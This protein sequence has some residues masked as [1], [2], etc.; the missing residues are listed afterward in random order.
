MWIWT[1][2]SARK[3]ATIRAT[4]HFTQPE[5]PES[6]RPMRIKIEDETASVTGPF[7]PNFISV[8][9]KLTGKKKWLGPG[10][11]QFIPNAANIRI[12]KE[13]YPQT[14]WD[15]KV[16]TVADVER[17]EALARKHAER[18]IYQHPGARIDD[19]LPARVMKRGV[20]KALPKIVTDYHPKIKPWE[21]QEEGFR[22][23]AE[24]PE[25][26]LLWEMGTGKTALIIRTIG[27]LHVND[28]LSGVV[29]VAPK[30]V[31]RQWVEDE[32][33]K[34]FQNG[35]KLNAVV[36][37]KGKCP[38]PDTTFDKVKGL[39]ILAIHI[40]ALRVRVNKRGEIIE[41]SPGYEDVAAFLKAHRG[42]SMMVIDESHLIK[43]PES[44]R[45]LACVDLGRSATFRRIC[46]GTPIAKTLIDM[47]SQFNFL[48]PNILGHPY[49]TT[50]K[51]EYCILGG[52]SGKEI[53]AHKN[54]EQFYSL[55][56]PHADRRT[57]KECLDLP[58][59]QYVP[60]RFALS[61]EQMKHYTTMKNEFMAM[62]EDGEIVDVESAL[63]QLLRLQQITCGYLPREDGTL[64]HMASNARMD[65]LTNTLSQIAGPT[66]V[67]SR[68]T[69]N[70]EAVAEQAAKMGR[71]VGL[72]YGQQKAKLNDAAKAD[73]IAGKLDLLSMN[74][75]SG[76]AGLDGLQTRCSDA[77]YYSNSFRLLDRLQSE[78]RTHRGGM[79]ASMTYYDLL[80]DRTVDRFIMRNLRSKK[81]LADLT[82]DTIRLAL[83]G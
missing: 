59:K 31:Q 36:W 77:I 79:G 45:T 2:L 60:V 76:G 21:H 52:F 62:L 26:A 34:H 63:A 72:Y 48:N 81:D 4:P 18:S 28:K 7:P 5:I 56:A 57:K 70:I 23:S 50:F 39:S 83:T 8:A 33:P 43:G 49:F 61:D 20:P 38:K 22:I 42:R 69:E 30:G 55:I 47:W 6:F 80:A 17:L 14:S 35:I 53:V 29:I 9:A 13:A 41:T 54:V 12:I 44:L 3:S 58:E 82:L 66:I 64:H 65:T 15:D 78:D 71:K 74:P 25:F 32:F 75:Q 73:F 10:E 68:F 1:F 16:G 37:E 67:W 46:T 19:T 11:M 27:H 24:R 40:D 51:T